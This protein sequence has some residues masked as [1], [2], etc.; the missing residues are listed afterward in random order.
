[1]ANHQ[2][3]S[4]TAAALGAMLLLLNTNVSAAVGQE[5]PSHWHVYIGTYTAGESEGIYLL[6]LDLD[7]GELTQHGLAGEADNPNFLA[8][9]P[10]EPLLYAVGR[11]PDGEGGTQG[12]LGAFR[13][14]AE[15]GRLT[16][17]N[18]ASSIDGGPCH[19]A[20]DRAGRHVAAANYGG[21][22]FLV[23]AIE[24]GGGV[25][26]TTGHVQHE[27]SSVHPRQQNPHAHAVDFAPDGRFLFVTDLG[28]DKVMIYRYDSET[29][30]VEPNDPPYAEVAPGAGP[31]HFDFHPSGDFAYVINELDNTVTAFAYDAETGSLETIHTVPTLPEDF[32]E[33][34]TTAE[35][36]VHPSGRFLYGSNR[37]HDSI[38]VF[39][40]DE[41]T[42][43]LTPAGHA[44]TQ[45]N[46]PRNFNVDPSGQYLLAAN[47]NSDNVVVFRIDP[48]TGMLEP[49]GGEAEVPSPVCVVFRAP[50]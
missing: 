47:Q 39:E 26:E 31:R 30:A 25:G 18:Q 16:A 14:D 43:E 48:G 32:E 6:E 29:G 41:T 15:S 22:S 17:V 46:T 45:G 40:I 49:T 8:L 20:V 44:S 33:D 4:I 34:N 13:I 3:I 37:G 12:A 42:G 9:H 28:I 38:A 35:V 21:G 23:R 10:T 19:I 27:G 5:H 11:M 24:D 7:T 50:E 2:R 1:M 36:R